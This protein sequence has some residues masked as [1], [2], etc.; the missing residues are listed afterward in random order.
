MY[1]LA[2]H[3]TQYVHNMQVHDAEALAAQGRAVAREFADRAKMQAVKA[4]TS[5]RHCANLAEQREVWRAEVTHAR[6][7]GT[8]AFAREKFRLQPLAKSKLARLQ[9]RTMSIESSAAQRVQDFENMMT[10]A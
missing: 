7:A 3:N 9:G 4:I 2:Q 6:L 1:N 8:H 10:R 5:A